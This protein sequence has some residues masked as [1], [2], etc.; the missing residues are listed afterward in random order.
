MH[1]ISY[2]KNYKMQNRTLEHVKTLEAIRYFITLYMWY[3]RK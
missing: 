1:C 2:Y 3:G